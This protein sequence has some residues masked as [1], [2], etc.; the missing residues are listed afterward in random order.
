L[1]LPTHAETLSKKEASK[2]HWTEIVAMSFR[3][4]PSQVDVGPG[5]RGA[6]ARGLDDHVVVD[7]AVEERCA[8]GRLTKE[9]VYA[10]TRHDVARINRH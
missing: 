5:W 9:S 2:V 4:F 3:R 6:S 10:P 8:R 1:G 7:P